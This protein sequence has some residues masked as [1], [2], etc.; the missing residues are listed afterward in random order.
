MS[1]DPP[2]GSTVSAATTRKEKMIIARA[3]GRAPRATAASPAMTPAPP[4]P[5]AVHSAKVTSGIA[6]CSENHHGGPTAGLGT[7]MTAMLGPAAS[8]AIMIATAK[9]I[10]IAAIQASTRLSRSCAGRDRSLAAGAEAGE[11]PPAGWGTSGAYRMVRFVCRPTPVL[12]AGPG[13]RREPVPEAPGYAERGG[14]LP[15]PNLLATPARRIKI[16]N[17]GARV[18]LPRQACG[19]APLAKIA[20]APS[21]ITGLDREDTRAVRKDPA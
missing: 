7:W 12:V 13:R 18:L 1:V 11:G 19:T 5:A 15:L 21:K 20:G 14:S 6:G 4:A 16:A 2:A 17:D 9:T 10:R 3:D 8:T